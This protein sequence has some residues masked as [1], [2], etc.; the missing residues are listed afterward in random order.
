MSDKGSQ[1]RSADPE[2]ILAG[3]WYEVVGPDRAPTTMES[4]TPPLVPGWCIEIVKLCAYASEPV[5][6]LG[7]FQIYLD[8]VAS[9]ILV[10][11]EEGATAACVQDNLPL[12][13]SK[14]TLI[15]VFA[16]TS[17]PWEAQP[18]RAVIE[19]QRCFVRPIG[20][21]V[22]CF[23]EEEDIDLFDIIATT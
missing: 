5:T 20:G 4:I 6:G 15:E 12:A 17:G 8:G 13:V 23:S 11:L 19:W 21:P 22:A 16:Y 3:G 10:A 1:W 7:V 14:G 18:I 2:R 9:G